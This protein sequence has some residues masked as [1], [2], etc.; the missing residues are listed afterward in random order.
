MERSFCLSDV[1][2]QI[3]HRLV[4]SFCDSRDSSF[5]SARCVS[6]NFTAASELSLRG[7]QHI[8]SHRCRRP[9]TTKTLPYAYLPLDIISPPS[10]AFRSASGFF[11]TWFQRASRPLRYIRSQ[12]GPA[13]PKICL[14]INP[15]TCKSYCK[16]RQSFA[17][18]NTY[19]ISKKFLRKSDWTRSKS[20]RASSLYPHSS[21]GT[22]DLQNQT[23]VRFSFQSSPVPPVSQFSRLRI[24]WLVVELFQGNFTT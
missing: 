12:L 15:A 14:A 19:R 2:C 10:L 4:S 7:K 22:R 5:R 8:C 20:P 21:L 24:S 1:L 18:R 16:R 6:K 13:V 23:H 9:T 3:P 11:F 17:E